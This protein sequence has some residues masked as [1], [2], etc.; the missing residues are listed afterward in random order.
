[1][2]CKH[3]WLDYGRH[4]SARSGVLRIPLLLLWLFGQFA[5]TGGGA[6]SYQQAFAVNCDER[7]RR[8]NLD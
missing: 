7:S 5:A 8:R 1:M 3:G 4:V 2:S 6:V